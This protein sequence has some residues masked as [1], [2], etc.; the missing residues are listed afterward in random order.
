MYQRM[1]TRGAS[2]PPAV[3]ICM[4]SETVAYTRDEDAS[5]VTTLAK[6]KTEDRGPPSER[7]V[8]DTAILGAGLPAPA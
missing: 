3:K 4:D 8:G 5:F 6:S 2:A 7:R 1:E